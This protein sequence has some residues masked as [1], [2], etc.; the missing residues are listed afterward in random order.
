MRKL[1]SLGTAFLCLSTL[2]LAQVNPGAKPKSSREQA[3]EIRIGDSVIGGFEKDFNDD[4]YK[5]VVDKAGKQEIQI[6]LGAVPDVDSV[7]TIQDKDGREIWKA[8]QAPKGEPESIPYLVVTEGVYFIRVGGR[9][10]NLTDKYTLSVRLLGP[11]KENWEAE[12]NEDFMGANE[13]RIDV[14]LTGRVNRNYDV[15]YYVVKIPD[16]GRD[17]V[18]FQISGI[19]GDISDIELYDAKEKKVG[20]TVRGEPG[21]GGEIVRMRVKPGTFYLKV[22]P[23]RKNK[24]GSEYTLYVGNPSKPPASPGEVQ[25]A[26]TKALDWLAQRQGKTGA[27]PGANGQG[28]AGLSLMAFIGGKCV[29]NDH[30]ANIKLAVDYLK[31]VYKPSSKY[32]AGSKE[33]ATEGGRLGSGNMYEQG[34]ATLALIEALVD[35]DDTGLEPIVQDALDLI[36]RAQNTEHKPETLKGPVKTDSRDY[37]GW[38]YNSTSTDSDISITGWQVLALKAAVNAGFSIPEYIFP[39]TAG[40][41][42]SLQGKKDGSFRYN[43]PGD[44]GGSCARAGM[45][46]FILQLCG[47]PQDPAIPPAIRF[48]QDNAPRWNTE[49]PGDGYPFYYWYYGTRAMYVSGGEDW[50]VWKDWMCRFLVDHQ[51]EDG[52]WDGGQKERDLQTYRTALGALMLEFCCGHVPIY[53]SPVKRTFSGPGTLKVDFEKGPEQAAAKAVEIIMDASNSMWGQIAGEAKITIARRVLT[54]IINGLPDTMKVGLRVYGHRFGLNEP[55][56]CTDTELLV[57]IG[58]VDKA[59]LSEIVKKV[60]LKGKTPLVL[61]V[62]EAIKDFAK[63]PDGSIILVTDGIESCD[64][65]IKSIAPAI[66]KAGLELE[67]NIVGFDIKEAGARQELESIAGSTGGR[68]LDAKNADELLSALEQTLKL[69]YVVLDGAGKE[70]DRGV[71]GG[72]A[73]KLN[74]GTY[75]VRVLLAPKPLEIKVTVKAGEATICTLKK[76]E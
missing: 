65:D 4:W 62:L 1:F 13:L 2:A 56:A 40:Y 31:S 64:G 61:S 76:A 43:S 7:I 25:Q 36:I 48:M 72:E 27:W 52:S 55:Q 29:P 22:S 38:R 41:V 8:N 28:I 15:D 74:A 54:Q 46:A 9:P 47:F 37:G 71:V 32:A 60:Q 21:S 24:S 67:V 69:E 53:M 18:L 19:P 35:T 12:P 39:V 45:G 5:L 42:R 44:S 49:A 23:P 34:I 14:P 70:V 66:K 50:R 17:I 33:A 63:I 11:W 75:T 58:P 10:K 3:Q 57:P 59:R 30:S 20:E 6:D 16:P 68:Y 51:F 73:I 26:L